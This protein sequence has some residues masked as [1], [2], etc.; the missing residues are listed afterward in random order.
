ME[1]SAL[2]RLFGLSYENSTLVPEVSFRR[3]ERERSG[4]RK[5]L[6]V[7]CANQKTRVKVWLFLLI[8]GIFNYLIAYSDW[9]LLT[10]RCALIWL[11]VNRSLDAYRSM[12]VRFASSATRGF[13]SPLLSLFPLR[14]E[15]KPLEIAGQFPSQFR[16][17]SNFQ[18]N[19]AKGF[20]PSLS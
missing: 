14:D 20:I 16:R 8:G 17:R 3:K 6:A 15:R 19:E 10:D 2:F 7:R 18:L 12:I 11:L 1:N 4:E 9:L 5:P 13:L